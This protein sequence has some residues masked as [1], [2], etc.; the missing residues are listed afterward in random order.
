MKRFFSLILVLFMLLPTAFIFGC[1]TEETEETTVLR[2]CNC[3][4]YI[5]ES[6]LDEFTEL[7]GI[8]VIY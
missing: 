3:E 7:T 4:D 6:L 8:E 5:D 1:A 2:V